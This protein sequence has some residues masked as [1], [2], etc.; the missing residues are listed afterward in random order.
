MR[1]PPTQHVLLILALPIAGCAFRT[2]TPAVPRAIAGDAARPARLEVSS[3]EV[4][5]AAGA[6]DAETAADVRAQTR[7]I[8]ADAARKSATGDGPAKVG[9]TVSL[10]KY[11]DYV[12]H[13]I[14]QD[15]MALIF[16]GMAAPS[17][18]TCDRQALSVDVVVTHDGRRFFGHGEADKEGSIYAPAR[19]RALAVALDHAL[20]DAAK[21]GPLD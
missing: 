8:L 19:K 1:T 17:G 12:A 9:V 18:L 5:T 11:E 15:G 16:W 7:K 13:A 6:A 2:P 21:Y 4:V 20:A 14:R 3:V 10:G